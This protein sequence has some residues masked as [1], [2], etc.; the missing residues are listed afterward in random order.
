MGTEN[1]EKNKK[2]TAGDF[3]AERKS[4]DYWL[5]D[6]SVKMDGSRKFNSVYR[7]ETE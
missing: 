2:E 6:G 4:K 5:L 3:P 7:K 1:I